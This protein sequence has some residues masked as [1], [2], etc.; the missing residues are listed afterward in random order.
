MS[1]YGGYSIIR[2]F[3]NPTFFS[4]PIECR[5]M[6][7]PLY[8]VMYSTKEI[9]TTNIGYIFHTIKDVYYANKLIKRDINDYYMVFHNVDFIF[10]KL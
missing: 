8:I 9:S 6:E 1:D 7:V 10:R 4:S 2:Q 3:A 5:I